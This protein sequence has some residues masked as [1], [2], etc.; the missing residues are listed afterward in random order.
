LSE[1]GFSEF[2]NFQ[3]NGNAAFILCAK[4]RF[5]SVSK[6]LDIDGYYRNSKKFKRQAQIEAHIKMEGERRKTRLVLFS[7]H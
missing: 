1:S 2:E 4:Q 6:Q 7:H 3:N 5:V